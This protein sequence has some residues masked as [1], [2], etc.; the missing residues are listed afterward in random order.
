MTGSVFGALAKARAQS[1]P[2]PASKDKAELVSEQPKETA[3]TA[4]DEVLMTGDDLAT[5]MATAAADERGR[6]QAI[7][8]SDAA[9]GRRALAEHLAFETDMTADGAAA[10]L[11][12]SAKEVAGTGAAHPLD[13]V[14]KA[15][16][17]PEPPDGGSAGAGE[18]NATANKILA[19][20]NKARGKTSE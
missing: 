2:D 15:A 6:I 17:L 18:G 3:K 13:T 4:E 11:G 7:L 12:K 14:M 10:L 20:R 5:A 8:Q 9:D 16:G 1:Q 19:A